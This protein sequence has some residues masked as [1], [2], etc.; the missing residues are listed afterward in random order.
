MVKEK[1]KRRIRTYAL[2]YNTN[3]VYNTKQG[4]RY[5]RIPQ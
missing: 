4:L 5:L 3:P 1:A 2:Q